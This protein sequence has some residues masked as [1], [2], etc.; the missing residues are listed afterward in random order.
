MEIYVHFSVR[1]DQ[2]I[3]WQMKKKKKAISRWGA[4]RKYLLALPAI[5]PLLSHLRYDVSIEYNAFSI[6]FY[7]IEF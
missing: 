2:G 6:T 1:K 5:L 4:M 7:I 3:C